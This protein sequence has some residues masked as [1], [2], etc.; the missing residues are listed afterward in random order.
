MVMYPKM[1]GFDGR[2][3]IPVIV[4][5]VTAAG[6]HFMKDTV[7]VL[8]AM[9]TMAGCGAAYMLFRP[10]AVYLLDYACFR[11][12]NSCRVPFASYM[13]HARLCEFF[14]ERSVEFQMRILERSGLGEETC[15]PPSNH[16][17]PPQRTM[18]YG[19]EEAQ[20]IL[21]HLIDEVLARTGIDSK[22]IDAVV[23]NCSLF[24][25]TPALVDLVV[26]RYKMRS[27]VRAFNLSGMGCSAGIC[28]LDVAR[29]LLQVHPNTYVMVI[30][31]EILSPNYYSGSKRSMLLPNCLF[32]IGAAVELLTNRRSERRRSKYRLVHLV[33]TH[34]GSDDRSFFC[35][36]QEEDPDGNVGISLSKDLM[37]VAGDALR[38]NITAIGPLVLP[39]TEQ[40]RFL[41]ALFVRRVVSSSYPPYIP[42]FRAAFE[43]FCV[44][45]GGRAVIDEFQRSLR[46]R[47]IDV[48]PSRMAL[49]RFGNTSSSSVWYELAYAEA[50]GRMKRGDRVWMIGF[51]S[52]FKCNS[53]VWRCIRTIHQPVGGPWDN[54]IHRYPVE[55]P[56][57]QTIN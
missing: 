50:K 38:S 24:S 33:R 48:E 11:P 32:R 26:N 30:S 39:A 43:H 15:L 23:L 53:A 22:E 47:G 57:I 13:E 27:N 37:S 21:F 1:F 42:N 17:L 52:G 29:N 31:T 28:S 2:F 5:A 9:V 25:P 18:E 40:L 6:V 8:A 41:F 55:V 7:V 10:R 34:R 20:M 4:A 14:D 12:M 36:N 46:L 54:C 44:H 49:H 19:R 51:G 45:A 16:Y 56:E 35:V 3:L